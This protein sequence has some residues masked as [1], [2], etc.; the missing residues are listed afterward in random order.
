MTTEAVNEAAAHQRKR[1]SL[2][3]CQDETESKRSDEVCVHKTELLTNQIVMKL[4]FKPKVAALRQ[5]ESKV[6]SS[7]KIK[8]QA[9]G[10]FAITPT[11]V[12]TVNLFF[13]SRTPTHA[14]G[15]G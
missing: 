4:M 2:G 15:P 8:N 14:R 12:G 1:A 10:K 5:F 11:V 9:S 6:T 7:I 13:R 3:R